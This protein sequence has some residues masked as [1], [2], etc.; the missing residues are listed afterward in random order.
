[1]KKNLTTLFVA[2][3]LLT[4]AAMANEN[5]EPSLQAKNEFNRMFAQA[6]EVKW[7]SVANLDKVTFIHAGQHLTAFFNSL[8]EFES[9]SRNI[10]ISTLPLLLQKGL[11]DKLWASWVSESF[12]VAG[13][14][15]TKYYVTIENAN[16]KTIY[17]SSSTEWYV[18]KKSQ[19]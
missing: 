14:N 2:L 18:Y 19:K 16:E 11:Q 17:S 7:E 15:G 4:S 5:N 1:M 13:T 3:V 9:V 8:G 6:T 12:E 10:S